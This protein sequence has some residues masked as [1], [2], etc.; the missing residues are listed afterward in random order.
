[1]VSWNTIFSDNNAKTRI[2]YFE[3]SIPGKNVCFYFGLSAVF[4]CP[5]GHRGC[6]TL[7]KQTRKTTGCSDGSSYQTNW[8]NRDRF[9]LPNL[10]KKKSIYMHISKQLHDQRRGKT[11]VNIGDAFKRRRQLTA[12]KDAE[13]A[14]FFL[15]R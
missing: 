6:Q 5:F 8:I 7:N 3:I 2:F 14:N 11:S 13:L 10:K 1:M 9:I 15:N 4:N 12:Q